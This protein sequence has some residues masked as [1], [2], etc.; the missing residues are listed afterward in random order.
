MENHQRLSGVLPPVLPINPIRAKGGVHYDRRR[1]AGVMFTSMPVGTRS[2]HVPFNEG[3]MVKSPKQ[4]LR[5]SASRNR[6]GSREGVTA[7]W[8]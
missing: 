3:S 4:Y 6:H 8:V 2:V 1:R 5:W 7:G